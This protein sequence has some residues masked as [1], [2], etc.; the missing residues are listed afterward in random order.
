[1]LRKIAISQCFPDRY[2][3]GGHI[4]SFRLPLASGRGRGDVGASRAV[5]ADSADDFGDGGTTLP[6]REGYFLAAAPAAPF[7]AFE[8][9]DPMEALVNLKSCSTL[10]LHVRKFNSS[11]GKRCILLDDIR[12]LKT[13]KS[14][15]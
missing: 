6:G 12:L 2:S 8:E 5:G 4:L 13:V 7:A 11:L 3:Q 15:I 1:M 14:V 10:Y 9:D